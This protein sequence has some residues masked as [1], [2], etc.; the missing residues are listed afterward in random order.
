M[1]ALPFILPPLTP[2]AWPFLQILFGAR[3]LAIETLDPYFTRV[4]YDKIRTTERDYQAFMLGFALPSLLLMSV[5]LIGPIFWG[6]V[7]ACSALL[8]LQIIPN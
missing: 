7:Q 1:L 5:P 2:Y 3:A 6:L 8:L 4:G